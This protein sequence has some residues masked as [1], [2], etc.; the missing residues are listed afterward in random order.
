MS[1]K[2]VWIWQR[3]NSPS[4]PFNNDVWSSSKGTS[5]TH[6]PRHFCTVLAH[7]GSLLL[8]VLPAVKVSAQVPAQVRVSPESVQIRS[9]PGLE[10]AI[11]GLL[12]RGTVLVASRQVGEWIEVRLYPEYGINAPGGFIH[13]LEVALIRGEI[14]FEQLLKAGV[15]TA[16]GELRAGPGTTFEI[17]RE[18]GSGVELT[19]LE[20]SA[21]WH[22]VR[23][24]DES[25]FDPWIG[26]VH[27]SSVEELGHGPRVGPEVS[28][29]PKVSEPPAANPSPRPPDRVPGSG[30]QF[31]PV[32]TEPSLTDLSP[33]MRSLYE[34][35]RKDPGKAQLLGIL[36]PGGGHFY[37][38]DTGTGLGILGLEAAGYAAAY[39]T[40]F[41]ST[42]TRDDGSDECGLWPYY[43][44]MGGT[45]LLQILSASSARNQVE[46]VNAGLLRRLQSESPTQ[47]SILPRI[48]IRNGSPSVGLALGIRGW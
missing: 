10:G 33:T 45:A 39:H 4:L 36:L 6:T 19:I 12:P 11:V 34:A 7:L 44:W 35:Q 17:L 25:G 8:L 2:S 15:T 18:V 13:E 16:I 37:T 21:D 5:P 30:T 9:E 3:R 24:L 41:N 1:V 48:T 29:S 27:R 47:V 26:Y 46:A 40:V 43:V 28:A 38:G 14:P 31:E 23:I 20:T 42:C 22:K 32:P